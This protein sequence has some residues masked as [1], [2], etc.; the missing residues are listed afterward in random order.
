[1]RGRWAGL[2]AVLAIA[3]AD[4]AAAETVSPK[5]PARKAISVATKADVKL[6]PR[7]AVSA[8]AD[9]PVS[10]G[11]QWRAS[12]ANPYGRTVS[13]S[14]A[15]VVRRDLPGAKPDTVSRFGLGLNFKY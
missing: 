15:G 1:M 8:R 5:K 14:T 13:D 7:P 9:D 12:N 10:V 11:L 3:G 4:S 2:L 6:P